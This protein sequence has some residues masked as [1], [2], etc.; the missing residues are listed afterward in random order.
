MELQERITG[1][2][3]YC[4][5]RKELDEKSLKAYWIDLR[6]FFE[7]CRVLEPDKSRIEEYITE[8][9]QK[10]RQKTVKRKRTSI[11][12]TKSLRR[13]KNRGKPQRAT[14]RRAH[15]PPRKRSG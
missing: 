14:E 13:K 2:L 7:F 12:R 10:Y 8:L 5:Y 3:N 15:R 1:Y 11:R 6:Q 4:R 9:H